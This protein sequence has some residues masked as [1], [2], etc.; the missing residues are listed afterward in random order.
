MVALATSDEE[1]QVSQVGLAKVAE[2]DVDAFLT[3][4][5]IVSVMLIKGTVL[6]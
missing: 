3:C 1:A 5:D 2:P 6:N 4:A